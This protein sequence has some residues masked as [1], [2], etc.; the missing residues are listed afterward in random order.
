MKVKDISVV[1]CN[2]N[3]IKFLKKTIPIYKKIKLG[4]LIVIDGKSKDGSIEYLKKEKID[5]ISDYGKG[6]SYSRK[7]GIKNSTKKFILITGPDDFCDKEF[8]KKLCGKFKKSNFEAANFL[9]KIKKPITYWDYGLNFYFNYIRKPGIN[10]VIGTP[11]I[12]DKNIFKKI[13]YHINTC[14]CDDTDISEQLINNHYKIGTLNIKCNQGN[15]NNFKN[16]FDKFNLY[17]I[18]DFNY[19]EF[20]NKYFCLKN[21]LITYYRPLKHF[22]CLF[23]LSLRSFRLKLILFIIIIT[24]LRYRGLL[25]K[26]YKNL[27]I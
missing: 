5:V 18:S 13:K 7:I 25:N 3:S 9:L 8:F 1:I 20:K 6:L 10:K 22:I 19:Y 11:T 21:L 12:F 14:G 4:Q 23:F 26:H 24:V 27:L 17:G 15:R 2:K 16:I